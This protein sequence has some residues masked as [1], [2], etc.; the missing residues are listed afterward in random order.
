MAGPAAPCRNA[1]QNVLFLQSTSRVHRTSGSV[2]SAAVHCRLVGLI[3]F[4]IARRIGSGR[5]T[6]R[7]LR[8]QAAAASRASDRRTTSCAGTSAGFCAAIHASYDRMATDAD[9]EG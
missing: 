6:L 5:Q 7:S 9:V 2:D 4:A 3:L 1:P 8:D